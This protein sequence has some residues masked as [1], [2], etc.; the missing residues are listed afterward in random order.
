MKN[1]SR[2]GESEI[3]RI[4]LDTSVGMAFSNIIAFFII[5]TTA[6]VLNAGGV[7]NIHSAAEAAEA[8]RPL[9]G[10]LTFVLFALGIVGRGLLAVP[11]LAGSAAYG[12]SE[13]FGWPATLEAKAPDAVGFYSIIAGA[14]VVGLALGYTPIN[15]IQML[16]WSAV[17][18]GIVA[19]PI[20]AVMMRL[21]V[22]PDVMGPFVI[23]R[24]LRILGWVAT[25]VMAAAVMAMFATLR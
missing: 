8:L 2:G 1:L 7:T 17:L 11:V 12:V 4:A 9:A 15:P 25:A 13:A 21:A 6:V 16:V 5:L 23:K 22:M 14:T 3:A 19:V 10:D 20:M 24:R 18:N